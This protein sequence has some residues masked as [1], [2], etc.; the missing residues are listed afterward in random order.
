VDCDKSG[1]FS[2]VVTEIP[3][4]KKFSAPRPMVPRFFASSRF[5]VKL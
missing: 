3:R 1:E 5:N 2:F 4:D